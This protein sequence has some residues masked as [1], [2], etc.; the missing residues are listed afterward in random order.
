M[1]MFLGKGLNLQLPG[2]LHAELVTVDLLKDKVPV[3]ATL[4]DNARMSSI[5]ADVLK[6][7]AQNG[8]G[9]IDEAIIVNIVIE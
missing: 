9:V 5:A 1:F 4:M 7:E 2:Q 8:A 6:A 3:L